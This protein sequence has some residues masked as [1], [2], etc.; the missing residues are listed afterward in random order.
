M[1]ESKPYVNNVDDCSRY[2]VYW[3]P[4]SQPFPFTHYSFEM[5]KFQLPLYQDVHLIDITDH[6]VTI[7]D[8]PELL[9]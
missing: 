7:D 1:T 4:D 5:W 9:I 3:I 8:Y 2:Y 6:P